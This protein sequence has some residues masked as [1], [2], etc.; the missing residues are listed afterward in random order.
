MCL[1]IELPQC[2]LIILIGPVYA[3]VDDVGNVS[4][5]LSVILLFMLQRMCLSELL[6]LKIDPVY[7]LKF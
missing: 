2:P 6:K 4:L 5:N 1:L 7:Y 3:S